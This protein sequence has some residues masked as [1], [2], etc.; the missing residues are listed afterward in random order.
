MSIWVC[1]FMWIYFQEVLQILIQEEV[2]V[3]SSSQHSSSSSQYSDSCS[4]HFDTSKHA[5]ILMF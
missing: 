3:A 5:N 4:Q 1:I 2:L